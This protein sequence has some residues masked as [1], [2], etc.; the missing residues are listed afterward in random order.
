MKPNIS[1]TLT[2]LGLNEKEA[3]VYL[4]LLQTGSTAAS[5]IGK[6]TNLP[7]STAR[8]ICEQLIK[9]GL[10]NAVQK[11]NAFLYSPEP[12]EKLLYFVEAKKKQVQEE[13]AETNRIIGELKLMMN[14]HSVLPKVKFYEGVEGIIEMFQDV[15]NENSP[16]Y[17]ALR[18][19]ENIHPDI[20][21][22]LQKEYIPHRSI[23][24]NPAHILFNDNTITQ[25]YQ[26]KDKDM[27]RTSLLLP[28]EEYPFDTCIHIYGGKV[29]FYSYFK[30]D[31]TGVLITNKF[32]QKT[33]MSLFRSA[34]NFAKTFKVNERYRDII[35]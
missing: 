8:F 25:E 2:T 18:M 7:R 12:P 1:T 9:K 35:I 20:M 16:L 6:R 29:A 17:G 23:L 5:A 26:K 11:K 24:K 4:T 31:L 34:W 28:S 15:L 27:N 32:I 30:N 21:N 22:Y 14:P 13:E 19:D 3:Q 10:C 33:Q